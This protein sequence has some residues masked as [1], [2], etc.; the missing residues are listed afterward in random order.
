M[1][2]NKVTRAYNFS[3]EHLVTVA[4]KI[5]EYMRRDAPAFQML[6]VTSVMITFFESIVTDFSD[7]LENANAE[8]GYLA[9][10]EDAEVDRLRIAIKSVQ[11]RVLFKYGKDSFVYKKFHFENLFVQTLPGLIAVGRK[12]A[13]IGKIYIDQ[14]R[15]YGLADT[16]LER[17]HLLCNDLE[18]RVMNIKWSYTMPERAKQAN[19]IYDLLLKYSTMGQEFF[20]IKSNIRYNNYTIV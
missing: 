10:T 20:L 14:L 7:N 8:V 6:G 17:I 19:E 2:E 15:P 13:T 12:V 9:I 16:Q 3:D 5:I 11:S 4:K 1:E 18:L